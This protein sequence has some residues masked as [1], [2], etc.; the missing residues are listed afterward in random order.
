MARMALI[1]SKL[2]ILVPHDITWKRKSK[3]TFENQEIT[4][5]TLGSHFGIITELVLGISVLTCLVL[6]ISITLT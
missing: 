5:N 6:A 4:L 3:S 1:V 2:A